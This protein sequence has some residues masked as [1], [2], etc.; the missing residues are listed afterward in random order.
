MHACSYGTCSA[1]SLAFFHRRND[2]HVCAR[3]GVQWVE[4]VY[5]DQA[6]IA[7]GTDIL[8]APRHFG[9]V[10]DSDMLKEDTRLSRPQGMQVHLWEFTESLA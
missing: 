6:M 9:P 8:D 3:Q 2:E 4:P 10:T 5:H 7:G 1:K